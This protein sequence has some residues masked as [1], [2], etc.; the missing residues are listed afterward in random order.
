MKQKHCPIESARTALA[1]WSGDASANSRIAW[2]YGILLGWG[3][4]LPEVAKTHGWGEE[5]MDRLQRLHKRA[6]AMRKD[7]DDR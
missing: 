3:E 5:D 4:A 1:F 2:I 7:N 6:M